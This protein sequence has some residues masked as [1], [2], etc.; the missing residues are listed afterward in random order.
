MREPEV[1]LRKAAGA[2]GCTSEKPESVTL[3]GCPWRSETGYA[4]TPQVKGRIVGH[5]GRVN[6][7]AV[8]LTP[9]ASPG[10][11]SARLPFPLSR[12]ERGPGGEDVNRADGVRG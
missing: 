8:P 10:I 4:E 7:T 9:G 3:P 1:A 11:T 6:P 12:R 5:R 2:G